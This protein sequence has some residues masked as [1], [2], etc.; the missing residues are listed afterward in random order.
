M[1]P[2]AYNILGWFF[3]T[4]V[5]LLFIY[6]AYRDQGFIKTPQ[7]T[8]VWIVAG[9]ILLYLIVGIYT[10]TGMRIAQLAEDATFQDIT[11]TAQKKLQKISNS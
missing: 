1:T 5:L 9:A 6:W 3:F 10:F 4:L 8:F 7:Q 2:K 11:Q